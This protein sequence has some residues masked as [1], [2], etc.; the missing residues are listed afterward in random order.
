MIEFAAVVSIHEIIEPKSEQTCLVFNDDTLPIL[1][2]WTENQDVFPFIP[3][4]LAGVPNT[5]PTYEGKF[6]N[7][8]YDLGQVSYHSVVGD[9]AEEMRRAE[10]M[11]QSEKDASQYKSEQANIT[12]KSGYVKDFVMFDSPTNDLTGPAA[13]IGKTEESTE[14][15]DELSADS[16]E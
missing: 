3:V 16:V 6:E 15:D 2:A 13:R 7:Y 9:M 8:T 10:A 4:L 12:R 5:S 14:D 1:K 11:T